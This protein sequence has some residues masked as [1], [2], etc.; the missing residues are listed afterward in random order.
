[1]TI[2]RNF[3]CLRQ[4]FGVAHEGTWALVTFVLN[5]SCITC[6]G[7]V[8][9]ILVYL[10]ALH[11]I[12]YVRIKSSWWLLTFIV[13]V[14]IW[15]RFF[16]YRQILW[17][18]KP[19]LDHSVMESLKSFI[20]LAW[21]KKTLLQKANSNVLTTRHSAIWALPYKY[22]IAAFNNTRH[23]SVIRNGL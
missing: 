21:R 6:A 15:R 8:S 5:T 7:R 1:M 13:S 20:G 2:F 23:I 9:C 16:N 22:K 19:V 11:A 3:L 17:H 4:N 18:Y 10:R 12:F 14:V